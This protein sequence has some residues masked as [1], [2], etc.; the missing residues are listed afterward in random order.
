[1]TV[2]SQ[3]LSVAVTAFVESARLQILVVRRHPT[4]P[5]ST[6]IQPIVFLLLV[7]ARQH[8]TTPAQTTSALVAVTLT[9][10]WGSM[11]WT[12][13]GILRREI[14]DGT[15]ARSVTAIADA[16]IVV[17]GKCA[18]ATLLCFLLVVGTS[19]GMALALRVDVALGSIPALVTG[20]LLVALAGTALGYL[21]AGVFVVSRHPSHLTAA[22]TYPILIVGGLIIPS[23]M[24]PV[25]LSY[26]SYGIS[27]SWAH[28]FLDHA[29]VGTFDATAAAM[30]VG[31]T[32]LYFIGGGRLFAQL[33]RHARHEGTL[34]L[35]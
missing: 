21:F 19:V 20:L 4:L 7:D 24:L 5:V 8:P 13:G 10:M 1:M 22:L 27:L 29:A 33:V 3:R 6:I 18:G 14:A 11:L 30:T 28:T 15:L 12:S 16:R 35:E 32:T 34:G 2:V 9:A 25:P 26:L 17:I 31:L 23:S